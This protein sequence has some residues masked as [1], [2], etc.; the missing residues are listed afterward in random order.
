MAQILLCFALL[1]QHAFSNMLAVSEWMKPERFEQFKTA[2]YDLLDYNNDG[3]VNITEM[4][5]GITAQIDSSNIYKT[6]QHILFIPTTYS[7]IPSLDF[8]DFADCSIIKSR[9][10]LLSNSNNIKNK[11][12]SFEQELNSY[13]HD[14]QNIIP[15]QFT[16]NIFCEDLITNNPFLCH[17]YPSYCKVSCYQC[18]EHKNKI[19][20][21]TNEFIA[22]PEH[23]VSIKIQTNNI[24]IIAANC[25]DTPPNNEY[26]CAQQASWGKCNQTW[27]Q[28]YCCKTCFNCAE[29]CTGGGSD[30]CDAVKPTDHSG[31]IL[32]VSDIHIEPWYNIDGS[33]EVSRFKGASANNMFECRD[34]SNKEVDCEL[35]GGSDAPFPLYSTSIDFLKQHA[36]KSNMLIMGGDTQAHS[37][38]SGVSSPLTTTVPDLLSPVVKYMLK[39][40]T[41]KN[42]FYAAGNND[43]QHDEIF[44]SGSDPAVNKAWANVLISNN[45]V[46]NTLNRKYNISGKAYNQIGLFS[47]TGYYIKQIPAIFSSK[48]NE[49]FYAIILNTNLGTGNSR[50]N[51]VFNDDLAW[52]KSQ[53]NGHCLIIGHHPNVVQAIIPS[54]YKDIVKGSFSGHV[55]YFQ[56]TNSAGFAILPAVTQYSSYVGVITG[57][58]NS[59]GNVVLNWNDFN[60]YLGAKHKVP[61]DDCW[62][63]NGKP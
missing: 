4:A 7:C 36:A 39:K 14:C 51:Q 21:L 57:G 32:F 63:Y 19:R 20:G 1:L 44:C 46:T 3:N 42:I 52:I 28:G 2:F 33:G 38:T 60:Q 8:I 34:S 13:F 9:Q 18:A 61:Q 23:P 26:T 22:R 58:L 5:I 48:N 55:H 17:E 24:N 11:I 41:A 62:G 56:P 40:F 50:Q 31:Q 15:P 37:Y 59:A 25:T 43:G 16:K 30:N 35:N 54:Q 53:S 6:K 12:I 27:M 49:N 10:Q 29:S 45:I 47:E